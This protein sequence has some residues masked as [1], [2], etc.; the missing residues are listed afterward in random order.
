VAGFTD[1]GRR[2]LT[3][4][5]N[6]ISMW[7]PASGAREDF[8]IPRNL[9]FIQGVSSKAWDAK[10]DEPIYALGRVDGTMEFWNL[11]TGA[12]VV[13]PGH[14]AGIST[15]AFS[16]DGQRLAT[17]TSEG[18]VKIW[19]STTRREVTRFEP[20]GRHLY[21]LAFSADGKMLAGAGAS[22]RVWVWD[23]A[24][25]RR[26]LELGGHGQAVVSVAFSPDS[27]VLATTTFSAGEAR[28][29]DLPS[30]ELRARLK[31]H[32]QGVIAVEFSPDGKTLVTGSH[33][34]K[35]K[36]WNVAT[37]QELVTLPF[38]AHVT[39]VR[40]SPDGRGLAIGNV[41]L[42]GPQVQLLRAPSFEEIAAAE[43]KQNEAA[44][45]SP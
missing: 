21:C 6:S 8:V 15:V 5:T 38:A 33:D 31:G 19:D 23:V 9:A 3:G 11:T 17:G 40:F 1:G 20:V 22:S 42:D 41:T 2:L 16:P 29:W 24:S 32:I 30:G 26:L 18:E 13:W 25:G 28:L 34:R 12:R 7:T 35:V 45:P 36:L 10:P 44:K 37:Y 27:R 43:A 4:W 14:D 39:T